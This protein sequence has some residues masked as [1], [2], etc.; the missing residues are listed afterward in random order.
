MMT[1]HQHT[2]TTRPHKTRCKTAHSP[3]YPPY[4]HGFLVSWRPRNEFLHCPMQNISTT[5]KSQVSGLWVATHW[6]TRCT[7]KYTR[8]VRLGCGW[9]V[10]GTKS[11]RSWRRTKLEMYWKDADNV[12]FQS[13]WIYMKFYRQYLRDALILKIYILGCSF[14]LFTSDKRWN[15]QTGF[16]WASRFPILFKGL[17]QCTDSKNIPLYGGIFKYFSSFTM[18]KYC[19]IPTAYCR[20]SWFAPN[21]FYIWP[22]RC[23]DSDK[24]GQ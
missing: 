20:G 8:R 13:V 5:Q 6:Q 3:S 18:F 15:I 2:Q 11:R 10:R 7:K 16:R 4:T 24:I 17:S 1:A 19:S 22:C 14:W 23:A 9:T 21:V 12:I